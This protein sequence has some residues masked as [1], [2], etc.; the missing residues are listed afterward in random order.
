M[1]E[2]EVVF[3]SGSLLVGSTRD[4][5]TALEAPDARPAS[6]CEVVSD[7]L[8]SFVG[9]LPGCELVSVGAGRPMLVGQLVELLFAELR[10]PRQSLLCTTEERAERLAA[11]AVSWF[12]SRLDEDPDEHGY[13]NEITTVVGPAVEGSRR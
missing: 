9:S 11:V 2:R 10:D 4:W 3:F 5:P 13:T 12:E 8:A 1:S 6:V 7:V